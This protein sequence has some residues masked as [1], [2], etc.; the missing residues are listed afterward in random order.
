[1]AVKSE[2]TDY[3]NRLDE[4]IDNFIQQP[5]VLGAMFQTDTTLFLK[6]LDYIQKNNQEYLSLFETPTE[7]GSPTL[8]VVGDKKYNP[9]DI[10]HLYHFCRYENSVGKVKTKQNIL[11]WGG[12]YGN[13]CKV[14]H[15]ILGELI[16]TYTI[17]DLPKFTK[18]SKRYLD[19]TCKN[20][21][22]IVQIESGSYEI[23]SEDS[24]DMF[25]ST[26]A[27]SES[28]KECTDYLQK[29]GLLDSKKMLVSLHQCGNHIP[30]MEE[31]TNLR[32]ILREKDTIEENVSVID[33]V[34]YYIFK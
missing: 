6:E 18:L 4:T 32:N 16:E 2:W 23:L 11:E 26:W 5:T 25:I 30:F 21:D 17:V 10:H 14:L 29:N 15:M 8:F 34:N 33:G 13:M 1:M 31:S 19:N 24:F 22:N 3:Q 12:G 28:P 9:N 20:T 7:Y 27:L